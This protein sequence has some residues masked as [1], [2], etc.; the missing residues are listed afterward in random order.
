MA[1]KEQHNKTW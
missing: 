1:R